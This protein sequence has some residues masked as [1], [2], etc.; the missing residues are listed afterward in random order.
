MTAMS[1]AELGKRFAIDTVIP[2][3]PD[4]TEYVDAG[5]I[6][7]GVEYRVVNEDIVLNN[8]KAHGMD[9][10]PPGAR[11]TIDEDGG[12]SLHVCD[13]ATHSEYLRFDMFGESPHYHYLC[14]DEYQL[15]IPYDRHACGPMIDWAL[16]CIRLRL[17][18]MLAFCGA[19]D[20]AA[21]VDDGAIEAVLPQVVSLIERSSRVG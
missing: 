14:R 15:N 19:E 1:E 10:P 20:L 12:V 5:V 7:I 3:V 17:R 21:H 4:L 18:P 2:P 9:R 16:E 11:Q 8:L 13:A 6:A